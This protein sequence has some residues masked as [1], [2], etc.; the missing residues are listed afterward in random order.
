[1]TCYIQ[2]GTL[3]FSVD[4]WTFFLLFFSQNQSVD[5][6]LF[7]FSTQNNLETLAWNNSRLKMQVEL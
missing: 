1:M 5:C 7:T 4:K 6:P 3:N 2:E